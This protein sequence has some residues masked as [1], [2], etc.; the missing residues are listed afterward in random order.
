MLLGDFNIP[1]IVP[2]DQY[3]VEIISNGLVAP[4]PQT[5][6]L[7]SNLAGDKS[8]DQLFF[9]PGHTD[10]DF[11]QGRVG[12]VDFDNAVF[13]HL[14]KTDRFPKK[15]YFFQYIRYFIS[16]H[17]SLWAQFRVGE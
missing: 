10:D 8:Y 4:L 13:K 1:E 2:G 12:V 3:Y 5:K 7:G 14:W 6:Y 11:E 15:A 9:F 16:D 17:R